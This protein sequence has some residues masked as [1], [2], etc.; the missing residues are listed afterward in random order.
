VEL[1]RRGPLGVDDIAVMTFTD[2]AAAE[3]AARVR[4]GLETAR[5]RSTDAAERE[6]LEAALLG[7][8]RAQIETIHAFA[9]NVL[10]E[11]P[12]EAGLDPRF[13]VLDPLGARQRFDEAW[14]EWVDETLASEV[15]AISN[16]INS[17]RKINQRRMVADAA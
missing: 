5:S 15:P 2:A 6:R 10:R 11:R 4:E 3:L 9:T 17:G 14:R 16:A 13:T 8:Y 7:L 12:V 1:L